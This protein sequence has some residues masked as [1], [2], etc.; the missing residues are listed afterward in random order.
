MCAGTGRQVLQAVV[1]KI[2]NTRSGICLYWGCLTILSRSL[3]QDVDRQS[4]ACNLTKGIVGKALVECEWS[5]HRPRIKDW[6]VR[7]RMDSSQ[8]RLRWCC[9]PTR[10][11]LT[12]L[13]VA[14]PCFV[15]SPRADLLSVR[16]VSGKT[17]GVRKRN[18][19]EANYRDQRRFS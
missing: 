15:K 8:H 9:E 1:R 18:V 10:C 6:F 3:W 5:S 2:K 12:A 4:V 13:L 17:L 11:C 16:E 19:Q 7:H 14:A